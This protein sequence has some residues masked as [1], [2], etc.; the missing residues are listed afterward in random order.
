MQSEVCRQKDGKFYVELPFQW[1]RIWS[2]HY[3]S[4]SSFF[5]MRSN[6]LIWNAPLSKPA[7]SFPRL[8]DQCA[9]NLLLWRPQKLSKLDF[10][11]SLS[12]RS[13]A[14]VHSPQR[15]Q[16]APSRPYPNSLSPSSRHQQV[17]GKYLSFQW[18]WLN[19]VGTTNPCFGSEYQQ[20]FSPANLL[21]LRPPPS[22]HSEVHWTL[23]HLS[24]WHLLGVFWRSRRWSS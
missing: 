7:R 17:F 21:V 2:G 8:E 19:A 11:C 3:R 15:N 22:Q 23:V 12:G 16:W 4:S 6:G 24:S 1:S 14:G 10:N 13:G 9:W 20:S 18:Y 5:S